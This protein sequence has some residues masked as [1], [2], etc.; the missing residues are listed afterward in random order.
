MK[1]AAWIPGPT[2]WASA[3]VLFVFARGVGVAMAFV[4]PILIALMRHSPRLA[5]LGMLIVWL[6]PIAAAAVIHNFLAGV[7]GLG[8]PES[9]ARGRW[10][11]GAASWWAGFF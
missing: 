5:W 8:K 6:S 11:G 9:S 7:L 4:M 3:V 2:A 1:A 10:L